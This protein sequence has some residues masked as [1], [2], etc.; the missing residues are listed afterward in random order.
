[1]E[2]NN[3]TLS[4]IILVAIYVLLFII[5]IISS[6][7]LVNTRSLS[8][9]EERR[10]DKKWYKWSKQYM[11]HETMYRTQMLMVLSLIVIFIFDYS[12]WPRYSPF[13]IMASLL[14]MTICS[15][16]VSH[17]VEPRIITRDKKKY[18]DKIA[19]AE[20]FMIHKGN[21]YESVPHQFT[22]NNKSNN[23]S[24]K[25]GWHFRGKTDEKNVP[26][27]SQQE[28]PMQIMSIN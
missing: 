20:S 16:L 10:F 25:K 3:E 15:K 5:P 27:L 22:S 13:I 9:S 19:M 14:F 7:V 1:M 24:N 18:F 2:M 8:M 6:L 28:I 12:E 23:K 11:F 4:T 21:I 26:L 17:L